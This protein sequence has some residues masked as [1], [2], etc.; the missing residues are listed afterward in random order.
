MATII[1]L[2][3][4]IFGLVLAFGYIVS[5]PYLYAVICLCFVAYCVYY[6]VNAPTPLLAFLAI[7][8]L[9]LAVLAFLFHKKKSTKKTKTQTNR[10]IL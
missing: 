6:L 3:V 9:P 5:S 4:L 7:T 1:L 10:Y 8:I 2:F